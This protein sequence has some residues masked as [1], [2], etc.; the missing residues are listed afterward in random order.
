MAKSCGNPG[1]KKRK[2]SFIFSPQELLFFF[3]H[4]DFSLAYLTSL[5]IE[6][7]GVGETG[8]RLLQVSIFGEGDTE[9]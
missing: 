6:K 3:P 1:R 8:L 9:K 7:G 5:F 4:L 2:K